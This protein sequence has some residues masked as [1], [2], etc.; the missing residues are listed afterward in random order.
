MSG[1]LVVLNKHPG[2]CSFEVGETWQLLFAK[3]ML[4]FMGPEATNVCQ[5]GQLCAGLK[6]GV[7]GHRWELLSN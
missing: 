5:Y 6:E 2:V 7:G 3:S 1:R 4:I